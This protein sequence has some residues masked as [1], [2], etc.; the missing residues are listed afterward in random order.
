MLRYPM[1]TVNGML[2][3]CINISAIIIFAGN[4]LTMWESVLSTPVD[5][6]FALKYDID[7]FDR[8]CR[9][10]NEPRCIVIY[11]FSWIIS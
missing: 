6:L 2:E 3:M 4:C 9:N 8:K 11:E 7:Y 5:I 1:P 10:R